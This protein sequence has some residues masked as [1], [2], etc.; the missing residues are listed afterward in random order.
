MT[1]PLR[2]RLRLTKA[3]FPVRALVGLLTLTAALS[4]KSLLDSACV[5][6]QG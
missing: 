5:Y 1:L 3:P 6:F 2:A 4:V